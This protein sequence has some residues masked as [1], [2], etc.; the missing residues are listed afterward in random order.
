MPAAIRT[1]GKPPFC[2][3]VLHGGPG[4]PGTMAPV[5]RELSTVCGI[6][7]P[8]QTADSVAGQLRELYAAVVEYGNP[9][10]TLIGSSWGAMLGFMFA[11]QHPGLVRKL[12]LVG[13]GVYDEHYAASIEPTRLSRLS[14]Q[15]QHAVQRLLHALDDP[16][17]VDKNALLAELGALFTEADAYDPLTLEIEAM[18][19][20]YAL[21]RRVWSEAQELRRCGRLLAMGQQITCPVVAIHG[22]YDPHPAE[23]VEQPL[24]AVLADFRFIL[25]ENCGHLPWIERQARDRFYAILREEVEQ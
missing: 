25:L 5:A 16:A 23:G 7:E 12:I 8:L 6:L 14:T 24:S 13:S 4:A 21:H 19:P 9:P 2:V 17:A 1:Y 20:Q 10:V 18:E 3:A 15:Q 22:D 11:A